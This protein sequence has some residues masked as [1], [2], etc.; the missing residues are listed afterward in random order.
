MAGTEVTE[1]I[2][3]MG[4]VESKVDILLERTA[5]QGKRIGDLEVSRGR[6]A[7]ALAILTVVWGAVLKFVFS[8]GRA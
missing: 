2:R 1:L 5:D 7:G 4:R 8:G 3:A 6:L